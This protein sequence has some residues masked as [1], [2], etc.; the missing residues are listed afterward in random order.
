MRRVVWIPKQLECV[1]LE[2]GAATGSK[3]ATTEARA[4]NNYLTTGNVAG[5]RSSSANA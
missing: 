3:D 1:S 5:V 4:L 2:H